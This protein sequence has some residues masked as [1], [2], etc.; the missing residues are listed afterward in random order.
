MNSC[1]PNAIMTNGDLHVWVLFEHGDKLRG[2]EWDCVIVDEDIRRFMS[3]QDYVN[4]L[5]IVPARVRP[6]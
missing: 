4:M 5:A 6:K 2:T 3:E 1:P